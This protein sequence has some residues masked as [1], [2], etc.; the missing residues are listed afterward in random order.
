LS[1][2]L[3]LLLGYSGLWGAGYLIYSA[4]TNKGDIA[5]VLRDL[6]LE[7]R[8]L[9]RASV[10][11]A[12]VCLYAWILRRAGEFLPNGASFLTAYVI[13][14]IAACT[15]VLFYQGPVLPAL[16]D[17]ALEGFLAPIGLL[18]DASGKADSSAPRAS[19]SYSVLAFGFAVTL[20]FWL[21]MGKG[22]FGT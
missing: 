22:I 14:G 9:W 12:G 4:L 17:A 6:A 13:A 10:G 8:W 3:A 18:F 15:S 11:I 2:F 1:T 5:F 19:V 21:T 16:H 7:P 20:V